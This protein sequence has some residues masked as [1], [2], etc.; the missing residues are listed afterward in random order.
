MKR[1]TASRAALFTKCLYWLRDDAIWDEG[2]RGAG[3]IRGSAVHRFIELYL[4]G[5]AGAFA[6][7]KCLEGIDLDQQDKEDV[8]SMCVAW[9]NWMEKRDTCKLCRGT[10]GP[11]NDCRGCN[12][13]GQTFSHPLNEMLERHRKTKAGLIEPMYVWDPSTNKARF[14][15]TQQGRAYPDDAPVG[16]T[17]DFVLLGEDLACIIDWK[18]V[19]PFADVP[20]ALEQL[21]LLALLVRKVD[22]KIKRFMIASVGI[23]VKGVRVGTFQTVN[24]LELASM[25]RDILGRLDAMTAAPGTWTEHQPQPGPHCYNNF[26]PARKFCPATAQAMVPFAP[27]GKTLLP[28]IADDETAD[29]TFDALKLASAQLDDIKAALKE[30]IQAR[31]GMIP[32]QNGKMLGFV[33]KKGRRSFSSDAAVEML[34][35]RGASDEEISSLWSQ[36]KG[37]VELRETKR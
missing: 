27:Q 34:R 4:S 6:L 10:G 28:I 14:V 37:Y 8:A 32:R 9:L 18:T 22:P 7:E 20:E 15:G 19:Q 24:A 31:G 33:E 3:A 26:C 12:G 5:T 35:A 1:L 16:G 36:G 25:E 17:A 21:L 29:W 13:D 2:A 23:D 30:Y 11:G